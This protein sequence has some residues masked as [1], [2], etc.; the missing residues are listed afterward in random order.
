MNFFSSIYQQVIFKFMGNSTPF[1]STLGMFG[2]GPLIPI[3]YEKV[4]L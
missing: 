2:R 4:M 1:R 3:H